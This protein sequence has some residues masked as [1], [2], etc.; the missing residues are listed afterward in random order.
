MKTLTKGSTSNFPPMGLIKNTGCF[1][2]RTFR[3]LTFCKRTKGRIV[4]GPGKLMY[5][6]VQHQTQYR[7]RNK[8]NLSLVSQEDVFEKK[9]SFKSSR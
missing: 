1:R 3:N 8:H 5:L 6:G 4:K 2:K 7:L 9:S